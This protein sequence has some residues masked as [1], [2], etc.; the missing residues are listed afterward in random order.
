[1]AR[2]KAGTVDVPDIKFE[3]PTEH[4]DELARLAE[5]RFRQTALDPEEALSRRRIRR[6]G[7][8]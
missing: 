4:A 3:K 5:L 8:A 2:P 7:T 1:V 6:R